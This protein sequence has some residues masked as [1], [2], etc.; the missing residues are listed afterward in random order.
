MS[1]KIRIGINGFGRIGSLVVRAAL[2]STDFEVRAINSKDCSP[3]YIAYRLAHDTAHGRFDGQIKVQGDMLV[4]TNF[5]TS[6]I[7]TSV[8][9]ATGAGEGLASLSATGLIKSKRVSKIKLYNHTDPA[10]IPWGEAGV[11]IVAE[12]TGVFLDL[13]GASKHIDSGVVVCEISGAKGQSKA[14]GAKKVVITAPPKDDTPMFV[15]GA[16]H[17]T[18]NGERVVSHASCTT[19]CLAPLAKVLDDNF[20]IVEGLLTTVHAVTASQPTVD[21]TSKKDW[22]GGRAGFNNIIPSST[23]AA[24][25]TAKVLPQ[26]EGKLTGISLRVPVVNVSCVDLTVRLRRNTTLDKI[27]AA[28]KKAAEGKLQIDRLAMLNRNLATRFGDYSTYKGIIDYI[29]TDLVSS[30]FN[31]SPYSAIYDAKASIMLNPKFFKIIAWYD[32]EW[33]YSCRVLDLIKHVSK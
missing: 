19:T 26:L 5:V 10:D 23:G 22:R 28:F 8:G 9:A 11:D 27:N 1:K 31:G 33:G 4:V 12:A 24:R 13:K 14:G 6:G 2:M 3:E 17:N 7:R 20:G 32:N 29:D 21:G 18:Y 16:N 15:M 30:D 25:A